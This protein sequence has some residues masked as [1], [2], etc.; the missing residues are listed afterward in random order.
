MA[1]EPGT[2]LYNR[3]R[4][5][6]TLNKGGM[7]AIYRAQDE[8]LNVEVAVKENLF[9]TE[10]YSR[11]F[12]REATILA[13]LHHPNLPR[14]TDHFVIPNQGQY[15][16]MDFIA[17]ED[18]RQRLLRAGAIPEDESLM[19][20]VAICDALTHLH[21]HTPPI[22]H[23]DIKPGNI[24]VTPNGQVFLVDF[25]LA[26]LV[27]AGQAT[28]VGAQALTPGFAPP[29]QYG[30]G[31]D[32]RSDIYA[33]GATLYAAMTNVIPEDGLARALRSS[34]LTLIR[35]HNPAISVE[36]TAPIEKAMSVD[37][38]QRFQAAEEFKLAL[39]GA[40]T[41]VRRKAA[42]NQ[43]MYVSPAPQNSATV[44][45]NI[46]VVKPAEWPA[47]SPIGPTRAAPPS[48]T[49]AISAE[50][51]ITAPPPP[52]P[53]QASA[54][55]ATPSTP[56]P[57]TTYPSVAQAQGY[58]PYAPGEAI[59][60]RRGTPTWLIAVIG[61]LVIIALFAIGGLFVLGVP[62]KLLA[63]LQTSGTPTLAPL[64]SVTPL[65]AQTKAPIVTQAPTA[66]KKSTT[67]ATPNESVPPTATSSPILA[68]PTD[69][70][71]PSPS[72]TPAATLFGGGGGQFA[73]AGMKT[74]G[75]PQLYL[76]DTNGNVVKPITNIVEG[77][78][79]PSWSP[80]GKQIVFIT[81][82]LRRIPPYPDSSLYIISADG[83]DPQPIVASRAGDFDPAWSP[84][85]SKIAFTSLRDNLSHVYIYDLAS[86]AVTRVSPVPVTDSQP[87]WS[88][89]G[90]QLVFASYR[91]GKG[92]IWISKPDGSSAHQLTPDSAGPFQRPFWSPDGSTILF[93]AA[94]GLSRMWGQSVDPGSS[95]HQFGGAGF[96]NMV[97]FSATFSA[98]NDWIFFETIYGY[99]AGDVHDIYRMDSKGNG[100]KMITDQTLL[101]FGPAWR[102]APK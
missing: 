61:A 100:P 15:L 80:D 34:Q 84:D 36:A 65:S 43:G 47:G 85:G 86:K 62:G 57:A 30:Q 67:Q 45:S 17:G 99:N 40:N 53:Q 73:I 81:P 87:A 28:T 3:Y 59:P 68:N 69:T 76:M 19:I 49:R 37:P 18:L 44:V 75:R 54:P 33:L 51:P 27:L 101:Y 20:G 31:T 94:S 22:L 60:Q 4:I 12:R 102:P 92:E 32:T 91:S 29:E 9:T 25:G 1:L 93:F 89:D 38:N 95:P 21:N 90:S 2:L 41:A 55:W 74:L 7:G 78:C 58:V 72:P 13:G 26:R 71:A 52:P 35:Q 16:V 48:S 56:G 14:V 23:R 46:P 98:D 39:L 8:S 77:A 70:L 88:P 83:G 64:P 5:L 96:A 63:L 10:D 11:Q 50:G 24:K 79:Q 97:I 6:E 82:C 42:E 66:T